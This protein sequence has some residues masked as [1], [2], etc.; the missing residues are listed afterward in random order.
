MPKALKIKIS[1]C[2]RGVS[3][4]KGKK[5]ARRNFRCKS[6]EKEGYAPSSGS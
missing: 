4:E 3:R 5:I 1:K 2:R 6:I